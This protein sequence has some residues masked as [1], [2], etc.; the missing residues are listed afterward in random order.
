MILTGIRWHQKFKFCPTS[1][2]KQQFSQSS[3]HQNLILLLK[4]C[5]KISEIFQIHAHM[6]KTGLDHVTFP[7]SKLLASSIQDM[8][9]AH[10]IFNQTQN[11]NLFI[12]N[13][14]LRGYSISQNPKQA[15]LFFNCIRAQGILLDQFSIISTLKSCARE[16]AVQYGLGIHGT[17]VKSGFNF[18]VNLR[19]TLL[20]FYSVCGRIEDARQ[21]FDEIPLKRDVVSWNALMGGYLQTSQPTYVMEL[22]RLMHMGFEISPATVL[23]VLSACGELGDFLGGESLHGFSIKNG[24][25]LDTNVVTAIVN[26]Y[27]KSKSMVYARRLFDGVPNRDVVLWNCIIDAYA[28]NVYGALT[29]GRSIHEYIEGE[30]LELNAVLGTALIDMYSKCGIIE[31][32]VEVFSRMKSKD[33]MCWTAMIVGLGVHGQGVKALKFFKNMEEEGVRPNEVTFLAVLGACSHGGLVMEGKMYFDRMIRDGFLPKIEHYGCMIDLLGRAGLVEEA[34]ELIKRLPIESDATAW[35]AL[36]AA[37][38]VHGHVELGEFVKGSLMELDDRH[39]GDTILLSSTYALAG[40]W[41]DVVRMWNSSEEKKRV[42]MK[43]EAGC[44]SIEMEC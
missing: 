23:S 9:Y 17:V 43:K 21:L 44:S 3:T 12:F 25:D 11:P 27:G 31:K 5:S 35:R 20:H 13:T 24:F 42:M 7:L 40:R 14:M 32:A 41:A 10:S 39:Y 22:F 8:D 38:R 4:S 16:L 1:Q 6:I 34:H 36:L 18:F 29:I 15:L 19:N 2:R 33:V 37:C 30:R 28:R 26:F